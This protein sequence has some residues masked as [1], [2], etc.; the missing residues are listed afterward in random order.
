MEVSINTLRND[1]RDGGIT[2]PSGNGESAANVF[3]SL[4]YQTC[5]GCLTMSSFQ[6]AQT[7]MMNVMTM[8]VKEGKATPVMAK[9]VEDVRNFFIEKNKP[10]PQTVY[11]N[12]TISSNMNSHNNN[13]NSNNNTDSGTVENHFDG[14]IDNFTITN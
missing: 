11:N 9:M 12:C 2:P 13:N 6:E 3:E 4:M 5:L 14:D 10:Q 7:Q 1:A 8:A